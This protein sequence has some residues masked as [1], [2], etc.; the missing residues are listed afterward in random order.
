MNA[1]EIKSGH[2][3]ECLMNG[4][5]LETLRAFGRAI[6]LPTRTE[7]GLPLELAR[8][9][10]IRRQVPELA[11]EFHLP[12]IEE[13]DLPTSMW[14]DQPITKMISVGQRWSSWCSGSERFDETVGD[15]LDRTMDQFDPVDS[16]R[17]PST[18]I[19]LPLSVNELNYIWHHGHHVECGPNKQTYVR[20]RGVTVIRT[21]ASNYL[22]AWR[23]GGIWFLSLPDAMSYLNQDGAE[24]AKIEEIIL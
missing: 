16:I 17:T 22:G 10:A 12:T 7:Q 23:V 8:L 11:I 20:P 2:T 18:Q 19:P 9:L 21:A 4:A 1:S 5:K 14:V 13:V 6:Y 3:K 15:A 24:R